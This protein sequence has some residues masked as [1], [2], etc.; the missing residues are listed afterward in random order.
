VERTHDRLSI[1]VVPSHSL[2]DAERNAIL[3]LC[4]RAYGED[5]GVLF[6][7]FAS[8]SHVL[9]YARGRLASHALWVTRYL[10]VGAG[11]LLRT[12]YVELVATDPACRGRGFASMVLRRVALEIQDFDLAALSPSEPAFYARLGWELWRGPLFI[13]IESGLLP[14]P[15]EEQVMILRL[16]KTPP[17]DLGAPLSAEWREGELW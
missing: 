2:S 16:P 3:A 7:T 5:L 13:R 10:Q 8:A 17:L 6:D 11:P 14:S 15:A 4:N 1:R 12:A 9:G